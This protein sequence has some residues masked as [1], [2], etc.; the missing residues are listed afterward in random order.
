MMRKS[1]FGSKAGRG[2]DRGAVESTSQGPDGSDS[3]DND[4]NAD[5]EDANVEESVDRYERSSDRYRAEKNERAGAEGS[6]PA[7]RAFGGGFSKSGGGS[8]TFSKSGGSK[9]SSF[10]RGNASGNSTF[11]RGAGSRA[12]SKG[13]DVT[14]N[15]VPDNVAQDGEAEPVYERSSER[16]SAQRG[17]INR[18]SFGRSAKKEKTSNDEAVVTPLA[19][20]EA[21]YERSSDR[22]FGRGS[23]SGRGSSFGSSSSKRKA[24]QEGDVFERSSDRNSGRGKTRRPS[25][26]SDDNQSAAHSVDQ[27][28]VA[29]D[30]AKN[31]SADP[32]L[33]LE[34]ARLA[35]QEVVAE[36]KSTARVTGSDPFEPADPFEPFEQCAPAGM[37]IA[38]STYSRAAQDRKK[39]SSAEESKRKRPQLSLRG[40]ALGYLSRREHSRAELS[41][42]LMPHAG[43]A[44]S[45]EILLDA[46][47]QE[48]WLSNARFVESVVHRRGGKLGASRI[49]NELKR[50]AVGDELIQEAGAELSKSDLARAREVWEK[51]YGEPP[52]TPAERAKQARF[53][54]ARGFASG[55][56]M[57][58]L[59]GNDEDQAG[60]P[61]GN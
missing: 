23:S 43:E 6:A 32:A 24:A 50:H 11:S 13:R 36:P 31:A 34:L 58:V 4:A 42:K 45:L 12:F 35:L 17:L 7:R 40:R 57:K 51:K 18:S 39:A 54:A 19:S 9:N 46:L 28:G 37:P 27:Q 59:K 8:S 38:E 44:D 1:R 16:T 41:R 33:R 61:T 20:E 60:E 22:K 10:S 29:S 30:S 48:G 47:E 56:I 5:A 53:L 14:E 52:V 3:V 26:S 15:I 55:T 2:E 25:K 21:V 49:V